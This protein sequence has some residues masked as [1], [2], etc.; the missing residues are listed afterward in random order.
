V[1]AGRRTSGTRRSSGQAIVFLLLTLTALV[2]VLLF[3]VDLHRIIQRKN[4]AQNAGDAAALAAAWWQGATINLV[5]ELNLIHALAL[6]NAVNASNIDTGA[7]DAI[8]N[9]QA[10][11]CFTGPLTALFA[12]QTAAKENHIY[13]DKDMTELLRDHANLV[14]TQYTTKF[15]DSDYYQEPWPGAWEQY[16]DMI[17]LVA[18]DG[19][20]AGPDNTQFFLDPATGHF[21]MEKAFYEAVLGRNWCWF[22]LHA[23]GWLQAYSSFHDWPALPDP[24]L[25]DYT[26]SEIFGVGLHPYTYRMP[27]FFPD[28]YPDALLSP[29]HD[30]GFSTVTAAQLTNTNL[31]QSW[32]TWYAYNPRDWN[33]WARIR[34]DD[35]FPVAGEVRP[36]YDVAGADTVV[37]V[38]A[39]VDRL[40]PGSGRSDNVVW[41]AAAKPFGYLGENADKQPVTASGLVLPAFRNVRLIPVDA[42]TGS[43]N[44][45]SDAEWVRHVR[46]H[47]HT[48]LEHGPLSSPCRY[49]AALTVWEIETFRQD[50][51]DWLTVYSGNCREPDPGGS[52][53]GGG[54]RRGH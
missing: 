33:R 16:A 27:F 46:S 43:E 26:D 35:G 50:G 8:T 24:E 4:Q 10:R 52:R 28:T 36:E 53:H 44:S 51:I 32:E 45:S 49:C 13:V 29:F 3:N 47:L 18:L 48:Y 15:E 38:Y 22:H 19:I 6:A 5:G 20:A 21:L 23:N 14:R 42:A 11:L 34:P 9:M 31:T 54:S 41:S 1:N 40:T 7:I 17:D 12:A 30:A 2:F 25:S 37:R 39:S